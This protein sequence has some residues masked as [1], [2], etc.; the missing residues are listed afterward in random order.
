LSAN[1]AAAQKD[2]GAMQNDSAAVRK[3]LGAMQNDSAAVRKDSGAAKNSFREVFSGFAVMV[4]GYG[5]IARVSETQDKREG[6]A[7]G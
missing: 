2:L 4:N 5:A 7:F 6:V 1:Q 3:D